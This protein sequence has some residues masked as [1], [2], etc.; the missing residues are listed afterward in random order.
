MKA[1]E[2]MIGNFVDRN[3]LMEIRG[4]N[5][6][7]KWISLTIYD[8]VNMMLHKHVFR[9]DF[10]VRPIKLTKDVLEA[11]NFQTDNGFRAMDLPHDFTLLEGDKDGI[12]EVFE[13]NHQTLRCKY[14]HQLQNLV[15]ILKGQEL[16]IDIEKLKKALKHLL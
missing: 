6:S 13:L 14:L 5:K 7:T 9:L 8:H 16:K 3:G 10:R 15:F 12:V 2:L 1:R 11:C 4:I